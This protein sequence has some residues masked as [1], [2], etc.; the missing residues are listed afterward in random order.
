MIPQAGPAQHGGDDEP[1][2]PKPIDRTAKWLRL[3]A[4]A[5]SEGRFKSAERLGQQAYAEGEVEAAEFLD[6]LSVVR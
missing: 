3:A 5:V 1:S 6:A 2:W 4:T